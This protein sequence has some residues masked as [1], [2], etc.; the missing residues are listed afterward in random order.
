MIPLYSSEPPERKKAI[1]GVAFAAAFMMGRWLAEDLREDLE[2][3]TRAEGLAETEVV[4]FL[5]AYDSR[6]RRV[7][8]TNTALDV[9]DRNILG[10]AVETLED[11]FGDQPLID[12]RLRGTIG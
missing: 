1:A 5:E 3:A 6:M 4:S 12:A 9:I 7:N 8:L 10:Q 2:A 11:R